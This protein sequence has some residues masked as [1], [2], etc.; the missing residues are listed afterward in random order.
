MSQEKYANPFSLY[1][2]SYINQ[3]FS[4]AYYQQKMEIYMNSRKCFA[5]FFMVA[6]ICSLLVSTAYAAPQ[7]LRYTYDA[8]GRL[9]TVN[10]NV[11]GNR[12]Y[13]YDAAGNRTTVSVGNSSGAAS[14]SG[15]SSSSART[16]ICPTPPG[17]PFQCNTS[18]PTSYGHWAYCDSLCNN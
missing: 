3:C 17:A 1:L 16:L 4:Y 12:N 7:T 13:A 6:V 11:N 2:S 18:N 14:S 8:L 5:V 9:V 10:D 15:G